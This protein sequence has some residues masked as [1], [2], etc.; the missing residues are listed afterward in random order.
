MKQPFD[1]YVAGIYVKQP[2]RVNTLN[3]KK[4]QAGM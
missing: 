4:Q 1:E 3:Q 2:E